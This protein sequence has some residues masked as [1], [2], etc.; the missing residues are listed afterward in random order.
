MTDTDFPGASSPLPSDLG[1][2]HRLL[3]CAC[4]NDK[5]THWLANSFT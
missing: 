4:L 3:A 1:T 2:Q 5:N